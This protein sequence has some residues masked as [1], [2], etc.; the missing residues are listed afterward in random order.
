MENNNPP[1]LIEAK[2]C[3]TLIHRGDENFCFQTF[4]DN[5]SVSKKL[6]PSLSKVIHGSLDQVSAE[7]T[8]LNKRG[9]GIFYT[10]NKIKEGVKRKKQ[11]VI[12]VKAVFLDLDHSPLDPV[13]A[14][15]IKPHLV[16]ET[17]PGRFQC[18]YLIDNCPLESFTPIQ[19]ALAEKFSGD[20]S[21]KDLPRVA[22]LPGF[23][24][25]K[26]QDSPF[27]THILKEFSGPPY[28]V[29]KLVSEL[30]LNLERSKAYN[31]RNQSFIWDKSSDILQ[32]SR[33]NTLFH[34]GC[35][36]RGQQGYSDAKVREDLT[37]INLKFCKPPLNEHEVETIIKQVC[38]YPQNSKHDM[39]T[40]YHE[41]FD[42]L[43][44]MKPT[45]DGK[46]ETLL[47]NFT[48]RI[49][50]QIEKDDGSEIKR[51]FEIKA[52]LKKSEFLFN[53]PSADFSNL[54]WVVREIGPQAIIYPGFSKKE[55]ARTAIQVL[56]NNLVTN[57]V[58]T[59]IG[60]RKIDTKWVYLHSGGGID[61]DGLHTN[62]N[63]EPEGD[64]LKDYDLPKP[65][66]EDELNN[67]IEC[68]L[69]LIDLAPAKIIFPL[70][71]SIFRSVL[72][73]I[74]GIDLALF[75]VGPTGCQKSEV[76][77]LGQSFFGSGFTGKKIPGNWN[78]T[79]NS[80]E[81]QAF[82]I[83]DAIFTVDDFAPCGTQADVQR[84]H[85]EADRLF[86]AQG[87]RAGRGRMKSDGS[88]R[89]ENYPRGLIVSSGEDLPRGQSLRSRLFVIE[90]SK[91]DIK[92]DELTIA[93]K[94]A[95]NGVFAQL[96]AGYIQFLAP[97]LDDLKE[98]F[99]QR[100]LDFREQARQLEFA[101]DRTPDI[102]ATLMLGWELF[103]DFAQFNGAIVEEEKTKL[104]NSCW[105]TL[106][107]VSSNQLS[108]QS[109]EE[110][111]MRFMELVFSAFSSKKAHVTSTAGSEPDDPEEWGWTSRTIGTG[112][113]ERDEWIPHGNSIGWVDDNGNLFLNP[114]EAFAAVQRL[115]KDQGTSLSIT[116]T[117]LWKRLDERG[118]I[119]S[120]EP[121]QK[122]IP[123]RKIF[124]KRRYYVLHINYSS[125]L[126]PKND[127]TDPIDP[128]SPKQTDFLPKSMDHYYLET[129]KP[130][131][132]TDPQ[133]KENQCPGSI[134][135]N[136]SEIRGNNAREG[137]SRFIK[138]IV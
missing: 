106:N 88:L 66:L 56:S 13:L 124:G 104:W 25:Q 78:T 83:K 80:L 48:A 5:K 61:A 37:A 20:P 64:R 59:H 69:R 130:I 54:N 45:K 77:G 14:A 50:S 107:E 16:I 112:T 99:N 122:R 21:V 120:K 76:T 62:I 87:N 123:I 79:A 113:Y 109:F 49:V 121:S 105:A 8:E 75:F 42:G 31:N 4:A 97:R 103:L 125:F 131:H 126:C 135:S 91:G 128:P 95:G 110:P 114:N 51:N 36:Y 71:S 93:Q 108:H 52:K 39:E 63:V 60:W 138:G 58:F 136:G 102:V 38:M 98:S 41:K 30:E 100:F 70:L 111:A 90:I 28:T 117:I 101:H 137:S 11:N 72:G 34:T 89:V 134:G 55:H 3:L 6:Q 82:L 22:R 29:A 47:T 7:L 86:R 43:I 65:P 19:E 15:A 92:L 44:Y 84:L 57:R 74:K 9:A 46:V 33:N 96:M 17:S 53:I 10:I 12:E 73:E 24:H 32:S 129:E 119:A 18:I 67:A 40:D 81:R 23:D 116:A 35:Y 133:T 1:D 132:K 118:Y 2:R 27:R 94:N 68:T 26:N 85:K 127:P 115:S